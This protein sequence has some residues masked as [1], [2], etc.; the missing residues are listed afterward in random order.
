M[1][2]GNLKIFEITHFSLIKTTDEMRSDALAKLAGRCV[3]WVSLSHRT[4]SPVAR[5]LFHDSVRMLPRW[6]DV[7]MRAAQALD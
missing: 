6:L 3:G 1:R 7:I 2:W 5:G 4:D